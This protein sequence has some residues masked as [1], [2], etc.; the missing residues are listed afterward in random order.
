MLSIMRKPNWSGPAEKSQVVVT[1]D[2]GCAGTVRVL[3]VEGQRVRLGFDFPRSVRV[4]RA[5]V[6]RGRREEP[7]G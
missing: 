7:P 4:D 5:E 2:C 6:A 1:C 3:S